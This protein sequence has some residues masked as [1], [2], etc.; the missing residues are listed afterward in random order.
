MPPADTWLF[1][2]TFLTALGCA[3]VAGIFLAFSSFVMGALAR[4]NPPAGIAAMQSINVVVLNPLFLG[5]FM[6]TALACA[7]LFVYAVTHWQTP[8]ALCL[9]AGSFCY[10]V[11]TFGV[12]MAF[13]VP[14]NNTLAQMEPASAEAAG[15]WRGYVSGWTMWNHVRTI[16]GLVAAALLVWALVRL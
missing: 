16:A 2:L 11:G 6:G 9:A 1:A 14:R 4:I 13:N 5:L 3:L 15:F 7:V 10:V 8:A 12:T